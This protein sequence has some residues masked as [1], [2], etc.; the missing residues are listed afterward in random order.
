MSLENRWFIN[1]NTDAAAEMWNLG[2]IRISD[3]LAAEKIPEMVKVRLAE[4]SNM[5]IFGN[6]FLFFQHLCHTHSVHLTVSHVFYWKRKVRKVQEEK[7]K[8]GKVWVLL[9]LWNCRV[10]LQR[11]SK[12]S[13]ACARF[14]EKS[15]RRMM[16][17][18][19]KKTR[20]HS[21][22]WTVGLNGTARESCFQDLYISKILT[23]IP[24]SL[25]DLGSGNDITENFAPSDE[26]LEALKPIKSGSEVL[27]RKDENP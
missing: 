19:M 23:V 5:V 6:I 13:G 22:S 2:L 10:T 4:F 20:C 8:T 24:R 18:L 3:S 17:W 27:W 16:S 21:S 9:R 1:I 7:R 25:I 12:R 11:S 15:R 26:V 14:R